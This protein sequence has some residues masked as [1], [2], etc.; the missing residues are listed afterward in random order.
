M[1]SRTQLWGGLCRV[2]AHCLRPHLLP[3]VSGGQLPPGPGVGPAGS[4]SPVEV[5]QAPREP[6]GLGP[7]WTGSLRALSTWSEPAVHQ[8]AASRARGPSGSS[9]EPSV[10]VFLDAHRGLGLWPRSW[11]MWGDESVLV[12]DRSCNKSLQTQWLKTATS[13]SLTVHRSPGAKV[14]VWAALAPG[15]SRGGSCVLPFPASGDTASSGTGSP[16]RPPAPPSPPATVSPWPL[17]RSEGPLMA[18]GATG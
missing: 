1:H 12:S 10:A 18:L 6:L 11:G 7:Q 13:C 16:L 17:L 4:P 15:G 2:R 14:K 3:R 5:P 8:G 9:G